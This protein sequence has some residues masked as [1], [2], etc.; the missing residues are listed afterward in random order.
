MKPLVMRGACAGLFVL[1][2]CLAAAP[3]SAQSP[4]P[5]IAVPDDRPQVI[6]GCYRLDR[7]IYGPYRVSFCLDQNEAGS[8]MVRGGG[9]DCRGRLDWYQDGRNLTIDMARSRCGNRTAWTADAIDCRLPRPDRPIT[10]LNCRYYPSES[11]YPN[12]RVSA[13]RYPDF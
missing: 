11:G 12:L 10:S 8:Y 1:A 13:R 6:E 9:L 4:N 5:N 3:A 7:A 2:A